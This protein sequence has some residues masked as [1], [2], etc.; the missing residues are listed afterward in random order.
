MV[1]E[2]EC[3]ECECTVECASIWF[4]PVIPL[5]FFIIGGIMMACAYSDEVFW[6]GVAILCFGGSCLLT[7]I[8]LY[9]V[10][11]VREARD[12]MASES[13]S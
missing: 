8:A 13:R 4:F 12:R 2:C 1:D 9:I 3:Y 5:V 11:R 10:H 7:G 6:A